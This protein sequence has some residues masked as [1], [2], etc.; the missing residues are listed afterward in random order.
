MHVFRR[1]LQLAALALFLSQGTLAQNYRADITVDI[2][3][4]EKKLVALAEAIPED[5]YSW[6]P[7]KGVR[8]VSQALMHTASANFFFPSLVGVPIPEGI[9][10]RELEQIT[11][12]DE[13]VRTLKDSFEQLKKMVTAS[14]DRELDEMVNMP[15]RQTTLAGALHA[16]VSHSHEHLGQMIAYARSVGTVPPWSEGN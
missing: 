9:N 5:K 4:L 14:A 10:P 7:Q 16:A 13:V 1:P 6:S 12:K 8:S 3:G 15:G 11:T 2:E